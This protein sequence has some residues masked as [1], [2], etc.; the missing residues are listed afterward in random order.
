M[1]Q[2]KKQNRKTTKHTNG[3]CWWVSEATKLHAETRD[4]PS[5]DPRDH[6]EQLYRHDI[7][8]QR[9][10]ARAVPVSANR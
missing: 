5:Q 9:R 8:P 4:P 3:P 6:K 2:N 7:T 10:Y 1:A